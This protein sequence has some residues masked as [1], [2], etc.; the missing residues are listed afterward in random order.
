[1]LRDHGWR[2]VDA[3]LCG[4]RSSYVVIASTSPNLRAVMEELQ[5]HH[6]I[7][8]PAERVAGVYRREPL[9]G[10]T[11]VRPSRSRNHP[12]ETQLVRY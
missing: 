7:A 4:D 9:V 8:G 5:R 1:M 2:D 11:A 12:R 3:E 10:P 6:D